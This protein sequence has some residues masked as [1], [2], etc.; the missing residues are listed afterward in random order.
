[1]I[2]S[3]QHQ[4]KGKTKSKLERTNQNELKRIEQNTVQDW[5]TQT[6]PHVLVSLYD[7]NAFF[8]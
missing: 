7:K 3:Q 5:P 2:H 8:L 6:I 1:M 4:Q